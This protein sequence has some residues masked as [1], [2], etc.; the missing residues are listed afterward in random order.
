[1]TGAPT[2]RRPA[3]G[4][5]RARHPVLRVVHSPDGERLGETF[6][7]DDHSFTFGR[8]REV[9]HRIR[10][11][12]MSRAH[13]RI[14]RGREGYYVEDL[15][16]TN[17]TYLDG[18]AVIGRQPLIGQVLSMGE[19]LFV[20][21]KAP[22]EGAI[23]YKADADP[24]TVRRIYGSSQTTSVLRKSIAT[25]APKRTT[26]LL[27]GATGVGKEVAARAV[28]E[29]SGRDG[30]FVAVNCAAVPMHLAESLFFGHHK[31][32]FTGADRYQE[33]LFQRANGG[34]LFL[35]EVGELAAPLQAKLLRVLEEQ[36]VQPLGAGPGMPVNVRIVAAT[37]ADLE[38]NGFRDDL[39]ARLNEWVI[40]L[41]PLAERKADVL[42]LWRY[43]SSVES[44]A[45]VSRSYTPEFCEALLLHDWPENVRE[46]RNLAR[47]LD[48][49]VGDAP[50]F[51]LEHLDRKLQ[52]PLLPRFE[53]GE[54][55]RRRM[56][57]PDYEE[58]DEISNPGRPPSKSQLEA[59][60]RLVR[61]NVQRV[62]NKNRWHRTQVYRWI[63]RY[64]ICLDD[65]R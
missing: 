23:P 16:T 29:A 54:S 13:A 8:S 5:N 6:L 35:D 32:A 57:E 60:L 27:L 55:G 28:H 2:I 30:E 19:T 64:E 46:L 1:M 47:R 56:P 33:G 18:S 36:Y 11:D 39:R 42:D 48:G 24:A 26:V 25:I 62:A 63:R 43:F 3:A 49:L 38:S 41:P 17:G 20:I 51:T 45:G 31:Q 9:S 44:S 58:D 52:A 15:D 21:D 7:L 22:K 61:G 40:K 34:T 50:Q 65:F 37:N 4:G 10:D 53:D 14:R 12:R 59:E